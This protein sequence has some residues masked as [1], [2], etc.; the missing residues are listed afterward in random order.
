MSTIIRALGPYCASYVNAPG[1]CFPK[2][3]IA[4]LHIIEN[5]RHPDAPAYGL[6][7]GLGLESGAMAKDMERDEVLKVII[8]DARS[9]GLYKLIAVAPAAGE[10]AGQLPFLRLGFAVHGF[11]YRRDL[12][13]NAPLIGI[14]DSRYLLSL[15]ETA[16]PGAPIIARANLCIVN[17]DRG[18][19]PLGLLENLEVIPARRGQG[20]GRSLTAEVIALAENLGCRAFVA[21]SRFGNASAHRLYEKL[22]LI[23]SQNVELRLDLIK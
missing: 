9:R 15:P 5:G 8:G 19:R 4:R 10:L 17:D 18:P 2:E 22:G 7:T 13:M 3:I 21:L 20:I 14:C 11:E 23:R 16:A 12:S 6:I 1:G